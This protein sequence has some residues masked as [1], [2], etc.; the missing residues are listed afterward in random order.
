MGKN[1]RK[2]Y[3]LAKRFRKKEVQKFLVMFM[4]MTIPLI[5]LFVF[6][7]LPLFKMFQFSLY[8]MKYTGPRKYVGLKNYYEVLTDKEVLRSLSISLYYMLGSFIQLAL[9]LYFATL[10]SFKTRLGGL[11]KGAI[12]F[13]YL[14]SGIAVGF[15]F[16]FFYTR[17]F[18]LD[19]VL[20]FLGF[21]LDSLPYWLRDK[22][23]NNFALVA[24]SIWRYTG[25]NMVLFIGAIMSVDKELYESAS[26]DGAN[27][28]QQFKYIIVPSI[29]TIIVLNLILSITGALSAFEIP[30]VITQGTRGT[31]TFFLLMHNMAHD[32][33]KVGKASAMALVLFGI[34]IVVTIIQKVIFKYLFRDANS[35]ISVKTRKRL[36]KAEKRSQEA[37]G[38]S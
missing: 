3:N 10:L 7:Y 35:D 17:G 24:A 1:D 19:S 26:L 27:R 37:K 29:Q 22:S 38:F 4:F 34:I 23:V 14:V 2:S 20:T 33:Q 32:L 13:P 31:S 6:T 36:K 11:F 28:W 21:P 18:V 25:Q 8:D 5:L 9:A 16:R 12:F 15:I 30:F